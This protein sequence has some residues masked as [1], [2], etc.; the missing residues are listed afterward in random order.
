MSSFKENVK[1][2]LRIGI[3]R[4]PLVAPGSAGEPRR[5]LWVC[6]A[7]VTM[8]GG[9]T[10]SCT[11]IPRPEFQGWGG[12]ASGRAQLAEVEGDSVTLTWSQH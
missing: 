2:G 10:G 9:G 12:N 5:S 3:D 8:V 1:L 7:V 6:N 4:R 11:E